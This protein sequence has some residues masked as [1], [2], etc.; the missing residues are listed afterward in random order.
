MDPEVRRFAG[1]PLIECGVAVIRDQ[2]GRI[3]ISRRKDDDSFGG[4]WEFPGGGREGAESMEACAVR[5]VREELGV[6]IVTERLL[7]VIEKPYPGK[8]LRL[9]FFLCRYVS[10]E[11]QAIECA[12]ARWVEPRELRGFLFPPANQ[13]VIDELAAVSF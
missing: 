11:P 1:G 5:E 10:G 6:E 13:M 8:D 9:T 12:E 2:A 4:Y 3:L 7:R